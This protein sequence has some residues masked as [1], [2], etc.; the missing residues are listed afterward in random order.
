MSIQLRSVPQL[1]GC[2]QAPGD[3]SISHRALILNA[4]AE[5][6]AEVRGFLAADDCLHTMACLRA[7]GVEF[8]QQ[9]DIVRVRS[10][11]YQNFTPPTAPLDCGNSGTSMRLLA[12]V[13]ALLPFDS[14]LDGDASLRRRPMDRV[15]QPLV[16]MGAQVHGSDGDKFPPITIRGGNA[17][18]FRGQLTVA[19]AQVKSAI[20]IAALAADAPSFVQEVAPTRDHTELMLMA[21][22]ATL[23]REEDNAVILMPRLVLEPLDLIIP[24]D[25][26]AAAFWL[27]A[28][29][30]TPDAELI[31]PNVGVNPTRSGVLDVL[32]QMGADVAFANTR[33]AG[34]E[35][36][37][38]LRVRSAPLHGVEIAGDLIARAIDEL[39]VLAVAAACAEGVTEIRDAAE[40][41]LKES[42]RI[43]TTVALLRALGAQV[44]ERPNGLRIEGSHNQSGQPLRGGPVDAAGDHRLAMAAAVA[45]LAAAGETTL[46][47]EEAVAISY[48]QFWDHLR[49]AANAALV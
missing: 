34:A 4:L 22:G 45:A 9:D 6:E 15:L 26:S 28:G 38:D 18:P 19:S 44:E 13:A 40:L 14:T 35:Y 11:G 48:P 49:T 25:L 32:G 2:L 42:D 46:T 23:H 1:R 16:Q 47:G 17:K 33:Y 7:Y 37:A 21:M 3:K 24:G 10:R 20:L 36:V 39:P 5:G 27:V 29:S 41:R 12:G 8:D 31:L 43:A 30:I